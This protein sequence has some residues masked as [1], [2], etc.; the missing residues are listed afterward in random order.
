MGRIQVRNGRSK[1]GRAFVIRNVRPD[2]G[3]AILAYADHIDRTS[4]HNLTQPGERAMTLEQEH[5]WLQKNLDDDRSLVIGAYE[6]DQ[7]VGFMNFK[8]NE[9]RRIAHHGI[10]G[11]SVRQDRRGQG[12]GAELIRVLLDWAEASPMIEKVCLE[13]FEANAHGRA[14]YRKMGFVEECRRHKAIKLE[15][16]AYVDDILM[17]VWVKR[18]G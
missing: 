14:L 13:V 8:G 9:R 1:D 2:E 3:A 15:N 10:F 12:I 6:G 7:L 5:D 11:I 16:G 4:E 17:S 18:P